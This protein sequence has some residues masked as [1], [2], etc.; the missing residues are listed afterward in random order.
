M[1]IGKQLPK[2]KKQNWQRTEE[3]TG[4][5]TAEATGEAMGEGTAGVVIEQTRKVWKDKIQEGYR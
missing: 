4:E 5:A 2:T 3:K 1:H